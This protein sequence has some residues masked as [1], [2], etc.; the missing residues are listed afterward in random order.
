MALRFHKHNKPLAANLC[1]Q[2]QGKRLAAVL[3]VDELMVDIVSNL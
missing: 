1:T 2:K 3:L